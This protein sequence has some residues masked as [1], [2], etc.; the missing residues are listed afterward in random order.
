MPASTDVVSY[1]VLGLLA[2]LVLRRVLGAASARRRIPGLLREGAVII[3]VRSPGEFSAGHAAGSRNIPLD[4]LER[5]AK[6]LDPKRWIIV[7]CA[8]GTRSG[9]ARRW[10]LS[11]GFPHVLNGGSWRNLP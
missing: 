9:M 6:D 5:S 10:L 1:A 11:H 4:D 2:A 3:D 8:S 7:C